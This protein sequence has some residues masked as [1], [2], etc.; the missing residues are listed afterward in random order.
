MAISSRVAIMAA[1]AA[2][3]QNPLSPR[4]LSDPSVSGATNTAPT[5]RPATND[6]VMPTGPGPSSPPRTPGGGSAIATPPPLGGR[7][8]GGAVRSTQAMASRQPPNTSVLSRSP[9]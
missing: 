7:G 4:A 6:P 5:I 9:S 8:G 1:S 2:Q 3:V